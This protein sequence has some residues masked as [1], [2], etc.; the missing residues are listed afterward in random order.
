MP[1]LLV[2]D[3]EASI[4]FS[5]EQVFDGQDIAGAR[6]R[7]GRR[8]PAPGRRRIAGRHPAGHPARRSLRA[9]CLSRPAPSRSQEPDHLH[10]RARHDRHRHRGHEA[11]RLRLPGQAAGRRPTAAGG[12]PGLGHQPADARAD[13]RRGGRPPR[14][15]ARPPDRQR[16]RHADGLQADRPR[17]A[18]RTSTC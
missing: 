12:R 18:R 4:R 2:I 14:G 9:R 11:G 7:D 3:D 15:Q 5:I 1:K 10:H 6:R 13:H 16:S 17:G 8:R